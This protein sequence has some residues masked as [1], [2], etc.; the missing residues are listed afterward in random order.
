MSKYTE[1][2]YVACSCVTKNLASAVSACTVPVSWVCIHNTYH[3]SKNCNQIHPSFIAFSYIPRSKLARIKITWTSVLADAIHVPWHLIFMEYFLPYSVLNSASRFRCT[4][5]PTSF[6]CVHGRKV[7]NKLHFPISSVY[8]YIPVLPYWALH[9]LL[10]STPTD[11]NAV[12]KRR[13]GAR[14]NML[15]R[16]L[17]YKMGLNWKRR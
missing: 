4:Q 9:L 2:W 16:Y 17:R 7:N 15:K 6:R 12:D 10:K 14:L 13:S 3:T 5:L 1:A 11:F 8:F